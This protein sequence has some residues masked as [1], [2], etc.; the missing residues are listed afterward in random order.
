[1]LKN[2]ND[3][4][5]QYCNS[6]NFEV[7]QNQIKVIK[8]LQD[9]Y[10][11]NFKSFFFNAFTKEYPQKSFYLYG[12]VG[13][14]KTMILDFFFDHIKEKKLRLHFNEFML[15]FHDFVHKMKDKKEENVVNLFV[16]NLKLKASLIY[17][18]EFQVT[19]IVDAMILG[20]LFECMFKENIKI[21]LTS[22]I[23]ISELYKD[24]LQRDQFK[25]FIKIMEQKSIEHE[26]VIEDDYRKAKENQ[27]QRYFF[28]LNQ[29]TNFKINKFF[30]TITKDKKIQQKILD[31]KGRVFEIKNY[32][33]GISKFNFQELCDQNLGAED[34][35]EIA[36][37]LNFIVI[38][39][40]P[41]FNDINSNQQQRFITL[42]DIIY[43]KKIPLAIT[44]S[45]SLDELSSSRSLKNEFK[46]SISR[47][48]ELTSK[49]YDL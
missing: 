34:Y 6:K 46:R 44:A 39:N 25:P 18:D 27:K 1:M 21:I 37:N 16:K 9:Y 45:Q 14:G 11:N 3:K 7:N 29:E 12:D 33:E 35:L 13:V 17:F 24:G 42:L 19:N 41:Q 43:D 23:K 15:N 28:P 36:K 32:Y 31:I 26:L 10:K 8:K 38:E 22:N 20:K 4:F 40:V 49:H 48:Y 30:R 2:L 47:L 5:N